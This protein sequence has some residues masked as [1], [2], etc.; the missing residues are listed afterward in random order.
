MTP[1]G[2]S[3]TASGPNGRNREPSVSTS[4]MSRVAAMQR[5]SLIGY[6]WPLPWPRPKANSS[7]RRSLWWRLS[8]GMDQKG[9]SSPFATHPY[10]AGSYIVR[11]VLGQREIAT[12]QTTSID[13]APRIINLTTVLAH[14]SGEWIAPDRPVCAISETATRIGW[15]RH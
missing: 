15:A 12:V 3:V 9:P 11:K 8:A 14:A 6:P 5:E 1:N 7:T 13:Q 2:Q 4:S 10:P